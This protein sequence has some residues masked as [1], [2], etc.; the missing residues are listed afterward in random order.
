MK[1]FIIAAS[2]LLAGVVFAN[3]QTDTKD[4]DKKNPPATEKTP[5]VGDAN[6]PVPATVPQVVP[7]TVNVEPNKD[8][9]APAQKEK[10]CSKGDKGCCKNKK[11]ESTEAPAENKQKSCCKKDKACGDKKSDEAAAPAVPAAPAAPTTPAAPANK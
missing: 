7:Q 6:A 2:F 3:A 1:K 8:A 9:A 5:Q 4:K 10:A 11:T